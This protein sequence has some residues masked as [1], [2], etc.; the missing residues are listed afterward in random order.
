MKDCYIFKFN[1]NSEEP[2]K[3]EEKPYVFVSYSKR[4]KKK[5]VSS[6]IYLSQIKL[7]TVVEGEPKARFSKATTPRC[8]G[9]LKFPKFPFLQ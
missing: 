9:R 8:R 6:K 2:K 1:L 5:Q 3:D 7:A 4:S